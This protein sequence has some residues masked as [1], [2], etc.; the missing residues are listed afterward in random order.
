MNEDKDSEPRRE[1]AKRSEREPPRRRRS[2]EDPL[3]ALTALDPEGP[4]AEIPLEKLDPDAL[5]VVQ[6]LRSFGHQAYLVGGCVRDL[7]LGASPKDFDVATSAHPGEIRAIF[8]NCRLIGRRFRLAHIYF[9][10]GKVIETATFRANPHAEVDPT[11]GDLLI[12]HDNVFGTA[13]Q[14]A[15]R[16]DFTVNGLFYDVVLGRVIDYVNGKDDLERR[17]LRTIGDPEVRMQEDPVRILRAVRF[18]SKSGLT[19]EPKTWAAMSKYREEIAR[20]SPPRVLEEIFRLLR[21]GHSKRAVELLDEL[22][23][24][25][26]L[27]PPLATYLAEAGKEQAQALFASLG[28]LDEVI[29]RGP[30]PDDSILLSTL[31]VHLSQHELIQGRQELAP[32][33]EGAEEQDTAEDGS[34]E[35]EE[36]GQEEAEDSSP[37][38][39]EPAEEEA[40]QVPWSL[41]ASARTIDELLPELVRSARLPRKIAERARLLLQAQ[42]VLSGARRRK[43]SPIRFVKQSYFPDALLIYRLYVQATGHGLENLARWEA[44]YEKT[45]GPLPE[46]FQEGEEESPAPPEEQ[47]ESGRRSRRRKGR[48]GKEA[49]EEATATTADESQTREGRSQTEESLPPPA[50]RAPPEGPADLLPF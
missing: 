17:Q 9:R 37:I 29:L 45:L 32:S 30:L 26:I 12:T 46:A 43:G 42:R 6:R 44:R 31:L 33:A 23:A 7:L 25:E 28:L 48:G 14:D 34:E 21:T 47:A 2:G 5:K 38:P 4:P 20:C 11:S 19:I 24:L 40:P 36:D 13:E 50:E 10:G 27:L 16:R 3:R 8:R 1:R 35:E 39:A 41:S 22:D 15:R 18:A 49:A